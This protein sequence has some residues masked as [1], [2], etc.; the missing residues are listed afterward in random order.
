MFGDVFAHARRQRIEISGFP[1][2]MIDEPQF[3]HPSPGFEFVENG[4]EGR[5]R[6]GRCVLRIQRQYH[7]TSSTCIA[8][9]GECAGDRGVAVT[10][11]QSNRDGAGHLLRQAFLQAALLCAGDSE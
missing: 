3:G 2:V 8:Q 1:M 9:F 4:I 5:R 11:A 7:D 10:H 6:G